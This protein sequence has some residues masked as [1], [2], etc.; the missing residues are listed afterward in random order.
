M[1]INKTIIRLAT[2]YQTR[3]QL[4]RLPA[5]LFEDIGKT[6]Q[7]ITNELSKSVLRAGIASSAMRL[8]NVIRLVGTIRVIKG[9]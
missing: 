8:I 5:Y 1:E 6:Q 4:R 2:Q 9:A 7:E 3:Q